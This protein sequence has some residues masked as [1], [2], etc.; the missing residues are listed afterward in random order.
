MQIVEPV[1]A[2]DVD[3]VLA[4]IQIPSC[5]MVLQSIVREVRRQNPDFVGIKKL[6]A[7]DVGVSAALINAVN[8]PMFGVTRKI[9][10]I[11]H[12]LFLLGMRNIKQIVESHFLR[13]A[14]E[15][16]R[17]PGMRQYWKRASRIATLCSFVSGATGS[18]DADIAYT[19]GLFRDAGMAVLRIKHSAYEPFLTGEV[20]SRG[21]ESL[22]KKE[23]AAFK[24]H[25]A[26][27]GSYLAARWNLS[28]SIALAILQHHDDRSTLKLPVNGAVNS[29]ESAEAQD[30]AETLLA[31]GVMTDWMSIRVGALVASPPPQAMHETMERLGIDPSQLEPMIS[32]AR[33]VLRRSA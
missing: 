30:L 24:V 14:F 26:R 9:N 17:S 28:E 8:S 18:C 12:A 29:S 6:I 15:A 27:V 20:L 11:E 4:D 10:S 7:S 3:P 22:L 32:E 33:Q 13:H 19:Y 21:G 5:P 31:L 23:E 2:A 1:R 16:G 25:H